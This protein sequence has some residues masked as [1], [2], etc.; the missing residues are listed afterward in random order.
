ML[1]FQKILGVCP[2]LFVNSFAKQL[3]LA[4]Y[5][6][7]S[8]SVDFWVGSRRR[9]AFKMFDFPAS[10]TPT[11]TLQVGAKLIVTNLMDR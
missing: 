7:L 2:R 10:F 9:R 4:P 1:V 11:S 3:T 6:C 5:R 8:A